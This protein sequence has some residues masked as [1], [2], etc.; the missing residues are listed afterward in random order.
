MEYLVGSIATMLGIFLI[1][2]AVQNDQSKAS[3]GAYRVT[4]N[5]SHVYRILRP[6]TII[7]S[8]LDQQKKVTQASEH[9]KSL[10]VR[11]MV[12]DDKA[13]WIKDNTFFTADMV[14]D[15]LDNSSTKTVDTMGMDDVQLKKMMFIV[16]RL[17]DGSQDDRGNSGYSWI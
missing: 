8:M 6:Y 5:Q 16:E 17:T 13:Y 12:V 9:E 15:N 7:S 2:R 3:S 10:Y 1:M 14:D 11:V 4:Y